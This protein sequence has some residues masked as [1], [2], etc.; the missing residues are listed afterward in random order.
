VNEPPT[1]S[2]DV[3]SAIVLTVP[4][5][6]GFQEVS[7]PELSRD[8]RPFRFVTPT[9]GGCV[10]AEKPTKMVDPEIA[11]SFA[12][13]FRISGSQEVEEP[14]TILTSATPGRARPPTDVIEPEI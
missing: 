7:A 11:K 5:A 14:V 4:L 13:P 10:I 9:D 2:V 1:K 6:F 12:D 8:N 3:V